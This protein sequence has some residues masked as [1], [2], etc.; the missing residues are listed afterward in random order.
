MSSPLGATVQHATTGPPPTPV[1][2]PAYRR[3]RRFVGLL[4]KA[5]FRRVE[6]VGLE[7]LPSDRGG[8]LVAW[9]PNGLVDPALILSAFPGA[10]VFGARSGLFRLPI[11]GRL[12]HALGTVPIYRREGSRGEMGE[13]PAAPEE[14]RRRRNDAS[15][16]AL[17]DRL[18]SGSFSALFPEGMSHDAPGLIQLKT[19]AAR[20]YYRARARAAIGRPAPVLVP[21]GLHYDQKRVFRSKALVVFHPPMQLPPSLDVSPDP[22]PDSEAARDLARRLTER[23]EQE[24]KSVVLETDSWEMHD[25]LHRARKLIRAERAHRAGRDPGGAS[26]DERIV[27]LSRVW[28]AYR[29]RARTDPEQVA[30]L[31]TRVTRYDRDLRSLGIEDHELDQPPPVLRPGFLLLLASQVISVFLLLPPL[32]LVGY[33]VNLPTALLV[34]LIARRV[35]KEQKDIA[36]LKLIAGAVLFPVTWALWGWMAASL[37]GSARVQALLPW[38]PANAL[39]AGGLMVVLCVV[40]ALVMLLYLSLARATWRALRIRLTRETRARAF[41]RL[42]VERSRLCDTLLALAEGLELPGVVRPDGAVARAAPPG[43]SR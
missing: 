13:V 27:G 15:L 24:L 41:L 7:N 29:E 4:V 5:F 8:V 28:V 33:A 2:P 3:L 1:V 9:H 43:A 23:I 17:A 34:S 6:V 30:K 38:L 21:V 14:E 16:D 31:R 26:M 18:A 19:G 20:L 36:S 22:D 11:L 10:V 35:G 39:L 12:V 40:G 42:G 37:A 25:L 32:L